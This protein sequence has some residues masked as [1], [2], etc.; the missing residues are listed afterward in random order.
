MHQQN[1][2]LEFLPLKIHCQRFTAKNSLLKIHCQMNVVTPF[3]GNLNVN[4]LEPSIT[5]I[6]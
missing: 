1:L 6:C 5:V 3:P 4:E 2:Y